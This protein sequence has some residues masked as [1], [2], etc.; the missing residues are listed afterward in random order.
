[1]KT[2]GILDHKQDNVVPHKGNQIYRTKR[3]S[4]PNVHL[5]KAW[6]SQQE[7]RGGVEVSGIWGEH[8]LPILLESQRRQTNDQII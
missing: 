5:F 2:L 7:E 8:L 4:N 6:Y 1:M 3:K